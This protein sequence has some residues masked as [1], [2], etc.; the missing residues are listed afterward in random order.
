MPGRTR[1]KITRTRNLI[2]TALTF[3][4]AFATTLSHVT[5]LL[6]SWNDGKAK[7]SIVAW[8]EKVTTASSPDFVP[9]HA[10]QHRHHISYPR[11]KTTV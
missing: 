3:E 2:A 8:V 7:H 10:S 4:L 6:P 1:T 9:D 5:D 11:N